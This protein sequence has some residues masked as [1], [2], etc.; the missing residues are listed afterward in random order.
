MGG[1][2]PPGGRGQPGGFPDSGPQQSPEGLEMGVA[3]QGSQGLDLGRD[4]LLPLWTS[5]STLLTFLCEATW[6]FLAQQCH[7][8]GGTLEKTKWLPP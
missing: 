8:R 7:E 1:W 5:C 2:G 3:Q 4:L 6:S